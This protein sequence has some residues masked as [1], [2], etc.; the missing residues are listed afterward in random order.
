MR[1]VDLHCDT[2]YKH[3]VNHTPLDDPENE[4]QIDYSP[5]HRKLQCYAIWL[6]DDY[7]DS[8]AESIVFQAAE[9]LKSECERLNIRLIKRGERIRDLFEK[10][11]NTAF[12]TIE[13]GKALNGKLENIRAFS[14]LGA[15]MM[16]LTWNAHNCIGDGADVID[17][18][19]LT[20]FGKKTIGEMERVGMIIDISHA[21]EKLFWDVAENTKRPFVASHSNARSITEHRRNLSD[22][23]IKEIIKRHGLFGLNF[24]NAFLNDDPDEASL[25]DILRHTEHFL[26]LGGRDSLCFGSDFDGGVLPKDIQNSRIYDKIYECF[27]KHHYS[28]RTIQKI[29]CDNAL[30]FFENFDNHG[31]L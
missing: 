15:K 16:T 3:V 7:S 5:E 13:N 10:N 8:K 2:L 26:S 6:P 30:N 1:V 14:E 11:V 4:V 19:G 27:S 22:S 28:D 12:F 18:E 25:Y 24:H 9:S 21:S 23:Q 29:F 20:D 31:S 17:S